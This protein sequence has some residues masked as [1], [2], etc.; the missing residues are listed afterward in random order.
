LVA[1]AALALSLVA[2]F[3]F[4]LRIDRV[5]DDDMHPSLRR[6]EWLLC[7]P[8][9]PS[10]GDVVRLWDPL[11]PQRSALRRV[12]GLPGDSV[13][14]AGHAA[15]VNDKRLRPQAMGHLGQDAIL[16]EADR[17]LVAVPRQPSHFSQAPSAVPPDQL[18]LAADNRA[19]ALDSRSWGP[20]RRQA[21]RDRV[22]LRL[23]PSDAWRSLLGAP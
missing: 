22:L 5:R 2:A 7:G 19:V 21:I 4:R 3:G 8:G 6:G 12:L 20:V 15:I 1:L 13:A 14:F 9:E 10:F 23:G 11:D 17:Y 18:W 16:M